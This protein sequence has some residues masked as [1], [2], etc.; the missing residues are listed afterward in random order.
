MFE[1]IPDVSVGVNFIIQMTLILFFSTFLFGF[2]IK[3]LMQIMK[4]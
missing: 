3:K 2:S 4:G 1:T